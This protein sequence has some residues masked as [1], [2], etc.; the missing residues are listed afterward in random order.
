MSEFK[1]RKT[2]IYRTWQSVHDMD[3]MPPYIATDNLK[4]TCPS[5]PNLVPVIAGGATGGIVAA[6]V[7][8]IIVIIVI[9]IR[10]KRA[11]DG[12]ST[13][14]GETNF[15][16]DGEMKNLKKGSKTS[17][18]KS[19]FA[20][21]V[22]DLH[23]DSNL[24]F[25]KEYKVIKENSP[26]HATEAAEQQSTR[27]KNRY[28]NIL[29]Y[30]HSR[31]KLLPTEDEEGSDYINANYIPGFNSQ[32]EYI[33]TQGP[34]NCT[35]DDFWRMIWE[36]NVNVIVMLT[37]LIERGRRKCD[38]YWPNNTREPVFFGDLIVEMESESPMND[39][40][41]RVFS[42]KLGKNVK[43]VKHFQFLAWPDMGIPQ[44]TEC[45]LYFVR[46]VRDHTPAQRRGPI[47]VHC[48]AGVGRTG[49]FI[50][51]D[52]LMQHVRTHDHLDIFN[53]V[54]AMR[55]NR[56]NMVQTED[57]YIFIHDCIKDYIEELEHEDEDAEDGNVIEE[58]K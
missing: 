43:N 1:K 17:I 5:E 24:I 29:A 45:M 53:L 30:D 22:E 46:G 41:L 57:Q 39:Y 16:F 2:S 4:V 12:E 36:Q 34:Q 47:V 32:R 6:A 40:I 21:K 55:D 49:T 20:R 23:A 54:L 42:L 10:R 25:A 8:I 33:A 48:S 13:G 28:T 38:Q 14:D 35:K 3:N 27:N 9:R 18:Q 44:T 58:R 26:S 50:A 51:V 15:G 52:H 56:T 31:V 37:Q 19:Q 7:V 11:K